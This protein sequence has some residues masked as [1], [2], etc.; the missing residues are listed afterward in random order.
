MAP[1]TKIHEGVFA[2]HKPSAI[3]SAQVIRDVQRH[4][5]PSTL[6]APW[7]KAEQSR[8]DAE[9]HN[10]KN[11]RRSWKQKQASQVKIG[12]GG[13]LDPLAT[14]VLILGVGSGTKA[15][16]GFLECTKSYETVVLFG[17]AT[18]TYD[19]EGKIVARQPYEHVTREAVEQALEKFRGDI[20]QKPPIYSA[21]RVQGKRLYE[22]AREGKEVPVEIK[23]RPL[24]VEDLEVLEW[25]EGGSHEWKW[26]EQEAEAEDKV[27]AQKIM[28]VE[29]AGGDEQG[30]TGGA[31]RKREV[32]DTV[33]GPATNDVSAKRTKNSAE[34][35][36]SLTA[37]ATLPKPDTVPEET[38]TSTAEP[39]APPLSTTTT[40]EP[41]APPAP[42]TTTATSPC[43]APAVRLRMTVTSGFYVRSLAHDLG[44]ALGSL[45]IMASL[46]RTRQGEFELGK[47][48][49]PYD[50]LAK[51][52]DV[53]APKVERMLDDWQEK[54]GDGRS[55]EGEGQV[56]GVGEN[57]GHGE[58][59]NG[60]GKVK[61]K[62]WRSKPAA[63]ASVRKN[64][65]SSG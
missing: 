1:T 5:N 63:R 32:E 52:E 33:D 46:V 11:K 60:D 10:Q 3:T 13:T 2:I 6:F 40:S 38:L 44:A 61:V 23:E 49:L 15:L 37:D 29:T 31:K 35:E 25:Y 26:P 30:S 28:G 48:V 7:M 24:K 45:G 27:V 57:A 4:F 47:N 20:M 18:D 39:P 64:S 34:P 17:T 51:G 58:D 62:K 22:Y 56:D 53:W 54:H 12:H 8:K 16:H 21:L 50:D 9:S 59:G 55:K 42:T 41:T 36:P 19:N 65:S 43:P 14:G